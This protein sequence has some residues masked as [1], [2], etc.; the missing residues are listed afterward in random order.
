MEENRA[1][2]TTYLEARRPRNPLA[3]SA[4]DLESSWRVS[5]SSSSSERRGSE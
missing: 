3:P 4:L 1:Q 5:K 2:P